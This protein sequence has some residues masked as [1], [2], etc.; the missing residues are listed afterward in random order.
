MNPLVIRDGKQIIKN[1]QI[2]KFKNYMNFKIQQKNKN[3]YS[4]DQNG[5]KYLVIIACH[6]N[7]QTRFDTI[8]TNLRYFAFENC[9]KIIINSEN[10][11]FTEQLKEITSR[12]NNT[13]Y[14]EI[15]NN[16]YID[17]G[18]WV[19]VLSQLVNYNN[20]DYIVLT[21]DSYIINSSINHFL[22]LAVK[23]NVE[24]FGYN[25]S[26]Q[27]RYHY[28]SYLFILRKDAVSTFINRVSSPG[29]VIN[30]PYDI[31]L[32]YEVTMTDWF[33]THKSFL[34]IGNFGLDIGHNIF[35]TNDQLYFPLKNSGL[36]PF[37]KLKRIS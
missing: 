16:N 24:L 15:P 25:D 10:T 9:H 4:P 14:H 28:Q 6:C 19:H 5:Q 22:N 2:N 7:S 30:G 36:L 12:H 26:S 37:T 13:S 21:N 33:S 1:K 23:Y 31:V 34:K 29:P 20:Y 35:F 27:V 17:F 8:R 11:G 18:K 3:S 32:N